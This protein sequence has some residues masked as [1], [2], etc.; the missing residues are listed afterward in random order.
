MNGMA[1]APSLYMARVFPRLMR[2]AWIVLAVLALVPWSAA[3]SPNFSTESQ[4]W[5][6]TDRPSDADARA[7]ALASEPQDDANPA[8]GAVLPAASGSGVADA[9]LNWLAPIAWSHDRQTVGDAQV[10]LYTSAQAQAVA[11]VEVRLLQRSPSGEL[12]TLGSASRLLSVASTAP[13]AEQFSIPLDATI[14]PSTHQLALQITYTGASGASV[15]QF[16][17][18]GAPSAI[19]VFPTQLADQDGDGLGDSL[20]RRLGTDPNNPD[21]DG[22]GLGDAAEVNGG[23]DPLDRRSVRGS[24]MDADQD[25]LHKTL[26]LLLGASPENADTD[27]DGYIDGIEFHAG[28][29]PTDARSIPNDWDL[30]GLPDAWDAHPNNP[31]ADNDGRNDCFDDEDGDGLTTCQEVAYG[32]DPD[33]ADTDDDGVPD[34]AEIRSGDNPLADPLVLSGGSKVAEPLVA[35][36]T[37]I[38]G[39]AI[40][41]FALAGRFRL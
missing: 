35:G 29:D 40:I 24:R 1:P 31:D 33:D 32:T 6:L 7:F 5:F 34:G 20:E 28:T 23:S 30:D 25:G 27:G 39:G 21:T 38:G 22:D 17:Q 14:I 18:P 11:E 37:L 41:F 19:T 3:G 15:L 36:L 4:P 10:V 13:R 26:E 2:R 9:Q 12:T 8:S 16:G